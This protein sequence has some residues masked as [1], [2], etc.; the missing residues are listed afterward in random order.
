M[1][2]QE[3]ETTE[4]THTHISDAETRPL[5]VRAKLNLGDRVCGEVEKNSFIALPGKGGHSRLMPSKLYE[6]SDLEGDL[7]EFYSN[8]QGQGC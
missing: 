5:C 6:N 4:R 8:G 7:L 1:G 2:L 3:S